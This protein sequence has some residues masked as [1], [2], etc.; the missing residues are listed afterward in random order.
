MA[1]TKQLADLLYDGLPAGTPGAGGGVEVSE[2]APSSP[3]EGD[4]WYDSTTGVKVLKFYNGTQWLKIVALTPILTSISGS[5]YTGTAST[6]TLSGTNFLTSNL[7]VNF[8]QASDSIDVDVTV[9][10]TSDTSATVAV[11]SS[12]YDSV[13]SGNG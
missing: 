3:S 8:L 1:E 7:I 6:L 13:T 9:T 5:V 2:S 11:P 10:P 4:L 12:V